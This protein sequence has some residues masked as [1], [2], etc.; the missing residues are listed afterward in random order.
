MIQARGLAF[1]AA[2]GPRLL[3]GLDL[4]V[5]RGE[6]LGIVG[7]SGSGKTTLGF[8]LC[9]IHPL[10][11]DGASSGSLLLEGREAIHTGARGF[12]GMVLQNPENQ[13][14]GRTVGEEMELAARGDR[15]RADRLL[16]LTGLAGHVRR[17][18]AALSLGWKQRLSIAGM[19]A[20]APRALLLDEPTSY[21]DARA[22]SELFGL[23]DGLE[24]TTVL[25]V[26]HD[27]G[28]LRN[29]SDRMVR[30]DGGRLAQAGPASAWPAPPV[31]AHR[32]S[33]PAP[34]SVLLEM[35]EVRFAYESGRPLLDGFSMELRAGEIVALQGPNGS[36]K[37]T[38]LRLA[39][40]LLRPGAGRVLAVSGR[41][42][43][44]EVGLVVQNPDA[45]LFARTVEEECAFMPANL[46]LDHPLERAREALARLGL[47]H[48]GP[49]S[50]FTLSCGEKRRVGICSVLSGGP[51]IL[52]LDEPTAGL[53]AAA[54]EAL[55][56]ALHQEARRGAAIL[57][58][59]HDRPFASTLATRILDL[60][61][62]AA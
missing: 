45:G 27:E 21:L 59:T 32:P 15:G 24:G 5:G 19:L 56:Q 39:K 10:A 28:R 3:H 42:L 46:G 23:L 33:L 26:D 4:E 52:C 58:A 20:A 6:K 41:P 60:D 13:L 47:E 44:T 29:W 37:S 53:D 54:Q 1:D 17:E 25:V 36:G 49:R 9:G 7:P 11:L 30:L 16:A 43:M 2:E 55:A 57:F 62:A 8:H 38:L 48:L 22:A 40:G 51:R 50:P 61:G 35:R 18:V 12:G 34:G 31:L 14:L